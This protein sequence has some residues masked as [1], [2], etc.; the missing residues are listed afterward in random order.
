[1]LLIPPR[2]GKSELASI[3]FPAWHL[4]HNPHHEIVDVGYNLDLP[5][6]FSRAVRDLMR[7]PFYTA[8]FPDT[9][10][11]PESQSVE[12]WLTTERGGYTAVGVGGGLT[13][14]GAHVLIIDDPI[15]NIE[16]ADNIEIRNQLNDWYQTVA[17]TRLSPGGGVLVIETWWN[18]DDLAGRL[19]ALM[20][21]GDPH[22]DQFEVVKYPALAEE[23]E[24][25]HPETLSV[26]RVP[27]VPDQEPVAP[28]GFELLRKPGDP[29]HAERY[30]TDALLR[31]RANMALR[32]WS[33]LFQQ[34]PTP[35]EGAYF[36]KEFLRY[37][38]QSPDRAGLRVYTAW[39]FAIGE[40][41]TNDYTVGATILQDHAD[42][43]HV[44]EI[45]RF[46]GDAGT[47]VEEILNTAT[48]WQVARGGDYLVGF[49]DGQIW[50]ALRPSFMRRCQERAVYPSFEELKPLTDKLARARTLQGRMEHGRVWLPASA[51][52]L[53]VLEIE[54]LRF[55][56]GVHDDIVD[57][58]AW[59]ANLV[60][61]HPP[62]TEARKRK[63]KSWKDKLSEMGASGASHMAA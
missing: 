27:P 50:R 63:P 58:L 28:E 11:N 62:P 31:K 47:I 45:V 48:R 37:E 14:K 9:K 42:N 21:S 3:R 34:N 23:Y 32:H 61:R 51:P 19:Q 10:L 8:I 6:K 24:Y 46:R 7:D 59:A 55:P 41:Q 13:G 22:A 43:W 1:M 12:S 5:M 30:D 17:Y 36:K 16:E 49:E 33:A 57:A 52:W 25:R 2:H 15:K 18:D 54:L 40:K 38:P 20:R 44:V 26:L 53:K 35:D 60:V 4:G 29:L 39:D 56:A